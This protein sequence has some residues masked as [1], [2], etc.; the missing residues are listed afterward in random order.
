MLL[1]AILAAHV[2]V[3][4]LT[5]RDLARRPDAAVRGK[6]D[7]WRIASALNSGGSLAYWLV[8]RR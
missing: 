4:T 7:L 1:A 3:C 2:A 5:W 8:G 6:K